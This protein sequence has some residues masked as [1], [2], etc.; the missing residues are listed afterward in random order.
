MKELKLPESEVKVMDVIWEAGEISAKDTAFKMGE[1]YGW[2]KNTTYTVLNNLNEKGAL[3]RI[4]P[5]FICKPLVQREQVGK[6]EAKSVME[7]FYK[8]SASAFLSNFLKDKDL[9]NTEID[10][11]KNMLDKMK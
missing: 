10:E 2:K 4:E 7:R 5:G 9:S 6:E 1:L 8:G 11:I 3:E